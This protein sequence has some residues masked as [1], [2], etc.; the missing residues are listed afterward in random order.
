M[1]A[2][3]MLILRKASSRNNV[4]FGAVFPEENRSVWQKMSLRFQP[5]GSSRQCLQ[6][7]VN[8]ILYWKHGSKIHASMIEFVWVQLIVKSIQNSGQFTHG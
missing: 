7:C 1:M 3:D 5:Y 2:W 8:G 6:G 4:Y